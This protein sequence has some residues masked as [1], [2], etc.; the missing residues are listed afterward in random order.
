MLIYIKNLLFFSSVYLSDLVC[1]HSSNFW[2][3]H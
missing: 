3:G 2:R 1:C